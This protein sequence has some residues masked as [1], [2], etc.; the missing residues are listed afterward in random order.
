M[1]R[2]DVVYNGGWHVAPV[3]KVR[4]GSS[5]TNMVLDPSI[6]DEPVPISTW[7]NLMKTGCTD[8]RRVNVFT[9]IRPASDYSPMSRTEYSQDPDY[10][11]TEDLLD[12]YRNKSGCVE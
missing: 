1:L 6:C 9:A 5:V 12:E 4:D 2:Q 3:V 8:G 7:I 11:F 10:S